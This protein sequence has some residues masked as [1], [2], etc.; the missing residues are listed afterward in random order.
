MKN[1][2]TM[3]NTLNIKRGL[4]LI[5]SWLRPGFILLSMLSTLG[6]GQMW[7]AET[8]HVR[9]YGGWSDSDANLMT[10]SGSPWTFTAY[11][12]TN[13]TFKI[14]STSQEWIG[15]PGAITVGADAVN[16]TAGGGNDMY[17]NSI[18]T[19][20][21]IYTI[22]V[23]KVSSTY[24]IQVTAVSVEG[25]DWK[26]ITDPTIYFDNSAASYS[27][28]SVVMGRVWGYG[29]QSQGY[30]AV[31]L[32]N[33]S[34]T[35]LYY[36]QSIDNASGDASK[37]TTM[38]FANASMSGWTASKQATQGVV[39]KTSY[40]N[41][42]NDNLN[43]NMFLFKAASGDKGASLTKTDLSAYTDLNKTQT[44]QVRISED[45][46]SSYTNAANFAAWPGTITVARTYLSSATAS[47]SPSATDMTA[48]TTT[49]ALTSSITF[50]GASTTEYTFAG[51]S[52]SNSSPDGNTSKTYTITDAA[53]KYAFYKRKQYAVSYGVN[54]S[55]RWGSITLNSGSAITTTSSSTLNHGT[56][57]SFTASP[58]TG[59]QV[60][61][62]YSDAACSAGNRLQSGGTS[63]NAGTLTAAT[64]V[65]VKFAVRTGGV[66]TLS[67]GTGGQVSLDNSTWGASKTKSSITTN[68][69][70]NIYAQANTGYTF[71]S[72]SKTS[73]SGTITN[74]G[75]AST[76]FTPVAYEDAAL[77]ASF[78]ETMST[79]TTGN[80]Y[81]GADAGFSNPTKS[82]S[83][84]GIATT[85]TITAASND[86]GYTL[87]S[88]TITNGVRTDGGGDNANPIT[89][90]SDGTGSAVTVT[91]N[92]VG[93]NR[94]VNIYLPNS[95]NS[96]STSD[97]NWKFYK[98]PGESGNTVTLAVD[99]DKDDYYSDGYKLGINI[100][101]ADWGDK[102][103]KNSSSAHTNMD[104]HNCTNWGFNT[105]DGDYHTKLDLN[106]SGTYT[107]TL[108]NSNNYATQQLSVTYPD[109]SFV[110]GEFEHSWGEYY[111]MTDNG[112]T[113][114]ATVTVTSTGDKQ[115]RL[116][117]HG[118]LFGTST[119]ITK[120]A[121]AQTLSEKNM[122]DAGAIITIGAYVAGDYTFSYNKSTKVLTVTWPVI[123]QLQIYTA[124]EELTGDDAIG[125]WNWTSTAGTVSSKSLTLQAKT[126]YKFKVVYNSDHYGFKTGSPENG[127]NNPDHPMT[128]DNCTDWRLYDDGGDSYLYAPV[129]GT[130]TFNFNS[131]NSGNTTLS[132]DF[133]TAYTITFGVGDLNGS[134]TD[135]AVSASPSFISGDFVLTTTAV[136]FTKG[137]TKAGYV[138]KG[139]YSNADGTGTL[140][141]STDANWT[142]AASTR[143]GN[144]SVY[145]CYDYATYAVTLSQT[146]AKTAGSVTSKTATYNTDMPAI[147]GSG[148]LPVAPDGYAFMGYYDALEPLGTKYY[149][150]DGTSA[151]V[152][153]KTS[154]T[155]LYPY[156]QQAEIISFTGLS[157]AYQPGAEE[158]GVTA[159]ISPSPAGTTIVCWRILYAEN[160]DP[161]AS[162]PTF[163]SAGDN[164]V[165][166]VM[167]AISGNYKLEAKLRLG[168]NCGSGTVLSTYAHEFNVAG[169]HDVTIQYKCG[170]VVIKTATVQSVAAFEATSITAPDIVGYTFSSWTLGEGVR[171][172]GGTLTSSPISVTAI[173]TSTITANYTPKRMIYFKNTL[174]WSGVTVY[175]YKNGSYWNASNGTGS[176]HTDTYTNT[177][178][179]ESK[180][181]AMTQIEGTDIWYFD[182]EGAGSSIYY[183]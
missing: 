166:F 147:T 21:G 74:T 131:N 35:S 136:T 116:V 45:N 140:H 49:G 104:A 8:L 1:N 175:F 127:N 119:K 101:Q 18:P 5:K 145:A 122:A 105:K 182:A 108:T 77:T 44:I 128:I 87:T 17:F 112:T 183:L 142:S 157:A 111:T 124:N 38:L 50:T 137:T 169:S 160:D 14:S 4:N 63:Y 37:Y 103:W 59:Y 152:W 75:T 90:R 52:N 126:Q 41:T 9:G 85:A 39:D 155:T 96:W 6:V 177:P 109:K 117:S 179:S 27:N 83:S 33:I 130:Y 42:Y 65:Y 134:N 53:T 178:F 3:N 34:N 10:G 110:E 115:F 67:A 98:L 151:H 138:W 93:S 13:G 118:K 23:T 76:T 174:G 167:P 48:T 19:G 20:G 91:A 159:N 135:I 24:K 64:T 161:I 139:W 73:G 92:Y 143:T 121:N 148:S 176:H 61:G 58:S 107:F 172:A 11:W 132:V 69:A 30:K 146:G 12:S 79:L 102:W 80:S 7:G 125:N 36:T 25:N 54:S 15:G 88:W 144:I 26:D 99:I 162:Q 171:I 150:S 56:A 120:A 57:I 62:W 170:D 95:G 86:L 81:D 47:S 60:E 89:V 173:Y 100:Y 28:V 97:T 154:A 180:Y 78:T 168:D 149:N 114:T 153:D 163:T 31:T 46:G 84:I 55:T 22:T 32:S 106:V 164:T 181:G 123:N 40:T 68:T 113:E 16:L 133:P 70:F 156:F 129:T 51:W 94:P 29:G 2:F 82:V 72:W 141:S 165:S 66:V 158:E 71:S 43:S